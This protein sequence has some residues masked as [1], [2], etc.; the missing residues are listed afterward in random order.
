MKRVFSARRISVIGIT[1]SGKT[2][3]AQRL[4]QSLDLPCIELDALY[5]AENW[6]GVP[7]EV[8]Q[9]RVVS[10]VQAECWIID[11]NYS[12]VRDL[13]RER[14][15]TVVYL[16]YSFGRVLWQLVLRTI[17]RS[18][19]GIELWSG[20][21]ESLG[22]ALFSKD[23]ILLWMLKTYHRRRRQYALL[24]QQPQYAHLHVV[25]LTSPPKTREWLA[26]LQAAR[27]V[28]RSMLGEDHR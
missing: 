12:R 18:L 4:S 15:D 19:S 2:T 11:G 20:N 22:L 17:R 14:A 3:V 23:S 26:S 16:N 5:W 13:V 24:L 25:H 1:G 9:Q 6:T 10:A 8:F 21:R 7:E 27:S 28:P